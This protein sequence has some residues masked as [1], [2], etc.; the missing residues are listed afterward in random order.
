MLG[1]MG[2]GAL[3]LI[4]MKA[5]MASSLA[6]MLSLIVAVKKYSSSTSSSTTDGGYHVVYAHE[7][8]HEKRSND[9]IEFSPYRGWINNH[10]NIKMVS[11][12]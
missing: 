7:G 2:F 5:L 6:L 8:H 3:G 11:T 4:S 10:D 1:V 12:R 9:N